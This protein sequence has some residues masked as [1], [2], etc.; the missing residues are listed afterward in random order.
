MEH[1]HFKTE[2]IYKLLLKA[3]SDQHWKILNQAMPMNG[4]MNGSFVALS[5]LRHK[6]FLASKIFWPFLFLLCDLQHCPKALR[7]FKTL[8]PCFFREECLNIIFPDPHVLV[9]SLKIVTGMLLIEYRMEFWQNQRHFRNT[10]YF[11]KE[12]CNPW[13]TEDF[14][15]WLQW[16]SF[17]R[18]NWVLLS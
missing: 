7:E 1:F 10:K 9:W 4:C 12:L 15:D 11:T 14:K 16:D 6:A 17:C 13:S 18:E 8:Q 5:L 2:T 3:L